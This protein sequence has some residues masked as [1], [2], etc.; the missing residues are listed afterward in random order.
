MN[1]TASG[2]GILDTSG[3]TTVTGEEVLN[4]EYQNFTASSPY[5]GFTWVV[6]SYTYYDN[7]DVYEEVL[8]ADLILEEL[9]M[10]LDRKFEEREDKTYP[11]CG[12][13]TQGIYH[14]GAGIL[15]NYGMWKLKEMIV[16]RECEELVS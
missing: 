15:G 12:K 6:D 7:E 2:Q 13:I 14:L 4:Y 8:N 1:N 5:K 11:E 9:K 10:I 16:R 3:D